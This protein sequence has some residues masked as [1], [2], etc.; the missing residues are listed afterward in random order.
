M[1][2]SV[3]IKLRPAWA[4]CSEFPEEKLHLTDMSAEMR[5]SMSDIICIHPS[6]GSL[7]V[8]QFP[9]C[10]TILLSEFSRMNKKCRCTFIKRGGRVFTIEA[11]LDLVHAVSLY[12]FTR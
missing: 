8:L 10:I 1:F 11:H 7:R 5:Q 6:S 3:G 2:K 4:C 9:M 12:P